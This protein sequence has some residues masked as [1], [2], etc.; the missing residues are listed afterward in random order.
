[1]SEILIP[2]TMAEELSSALWALARPPQM[3]DGHEVTRRMFGQIKDL[4]GADWLVVETDFG[5][6]VH[7]DAELNGIADILE[8]W[9]GQGIEQV[10]IDRLRQTV[11]AH[12]GR[13][14]VVYGAFP[15]IFKL[16]E[17]ENPTGLG[18]TREQMLQENRLANPILP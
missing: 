8:P 10:D 17:A 16:Q 1:M 13:R 4:Q 14:M 6:H 15:P 5:I 11:V 7:P 9:V 12:R 3:S 18:R 2:S